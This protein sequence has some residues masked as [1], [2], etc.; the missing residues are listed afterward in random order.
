[1]SE[2]S[3]YFQEFTTVH[4]MTLLSKMAAN[5]RYHAALVAMAATPCGVRFRL[6]QPVGIGWFPIDQPR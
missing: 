1:L 5:A 3:Y 2:T 4:V 6:S